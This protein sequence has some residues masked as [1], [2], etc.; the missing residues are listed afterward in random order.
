M[1]PIDLIKEILATYE[2]HGWRLRKAIFRPQTRAELTDESW[3]GDASL[4]A[5]ELDALW[6]SRGSQQNREA[7]E[8]RL[9]SATQYA[10]FEVFEAEEPE[11]AR[12][13]VRREMEERMKEKTK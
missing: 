5:G 13:E 1:N 3:A 10:L 4:E 9:I 6:F 11:A 7:W 8:L 12:E 2:K